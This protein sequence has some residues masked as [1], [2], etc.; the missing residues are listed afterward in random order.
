MNVG[1]GAHG[2]S[3]PSR[4][5]LE[6][7]ASGSSVDG[8]ISQHVEVCA[9]CSALLDSIRNDNALLDEFVTANRVTLSDRPGIATVVGPA[10]YDI[11][12]EI[13][14]GSQGI[15]YRA[16][17]IATKRTVAI[18]M[19]LH[20]TFASER[21]RYRF[22][23]EAEL[24]ASLRHPNIVTVFDSGVTPD[25]RH[26]LAME[27]VDGVPLDTFV[28][29]RFGTDANAP[30]VPVEWAFTFM[31]KLA[32]AMSAAHRRGII[33]RDLKPENILV[34]EQGDPHVLDFGLAKVTHTEQWSA[35]STPTIAGEF[36]G[37]FAY[38]SPEQVS[39][40]PNLIDTVT[41]VYAMGVVLYELLTGQRP[42]ELEGSLAQVVEAIQRAVPA[43]P[44]SIRG[45][46]NRDVETIVLKALAKEPERRY[47]SMQSLHDDLDHYLRGEPI[48][49]RRHELAY[50][51]TKF[52]SQYR[53][54][55]SAVLLA[56]IVLGTALGVTIRALDRANQQTALA[57]KEK[58]RAVSST[59]SLIKT[60]EEMDRE[61]SVSP[62]A[63][64]DIND[65][66]DRYEEIVAT[67]MSDFPDLESV[68]RSALGE[69]FLS[70]RRFDAAERNLRDALE[71]MQALHPEDH[72]DVA[73]AHHAMG[74]LYWQLNR[75][76][77]AE[78]HYRDALAMWQKLGDDYQAQTA[79]TMQHLAST[80]RLNGDFAGAQEWIVQ[81]TAIYTELYGGNHGL[82]A[83]NTLVM[84]NIDR[85]HGDYNA[86]LVH[87]ESAS[88][89]IGEARD[90]RTARVW[91][92]MAECLISLDRLD[93]ARAFLDDSREL[94]RDLGELDEDGRPQRANA[95]FANSQYQRAR[96]FLRENRLDDARAACDGAD[97]D[98]NAVY[99]DAGHP[100]LADAAM[101]RGQIQL[102][103]NDLDGARESFRM[104]RLIRTQFFPA[105]HWRQ[106]EVR[107]MLAACDARAGADESRRELDEA[108][109]AL[110]QV[111][112][113]GADPL[114]MAGRL[115]GR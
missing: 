44:R 93:D 12:D 115:A 105:T 78:S 32:D 43:S 58:A 6:S 91:H 84:G 51:V 96:L 9:S 108:R 52:V 70:R 56:F 20:G 24:V 60:I 65:L 75:C 94:K 7:I 68:A 3:C 66:L 67:E 102:A 15:V 82:I 49:A 10:G 1:G 62:N 18:K 42:Y 85:D 113:P 97:R 55:I 95:D 110:M 11:I 99:G 57:I 89:M 38:A 107:L 14:R 45:D 112:M 17:Q 36:L 2:S 26:F 83:L 101:L 106:D 88:T 61:D 98:W 4:D 29:V 72:P 25:G 103:G 80:L 21:Q 87:Y 31:A 16:T 100:A 5:E 71:T 114:V 54:L 41:D 23:R 30:R 27:Y 39:A 73:L 90:F 19:I 109:T 81:S 34:D 8:V 46:L 40:D 22:E 13:H 111:L 47:R 63:L 86:A 104:A 77:D 64:R 74:K 33:H 92:N 69:A 28:R 48:S 37:T 76:D 79:R 35:S 53:L 50:R 59:G